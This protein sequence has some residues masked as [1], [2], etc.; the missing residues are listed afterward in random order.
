MAFYDD[1]IGTPMDREDRCHN[2]LLST[3]HA[4][5]TLRGI[6]KPDTAPAAARIRPP[7]E[8]L[9]DGSFKVEREA[10]PHVRPKRIDVNVR[11]PRL[12]WVSKMA[13]Q[14]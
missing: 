11:T 3:P 14:L 4:V 6:H 2:N 7:D 1:R 13:C 12:S 5:K 10:Q 9:A 8:T